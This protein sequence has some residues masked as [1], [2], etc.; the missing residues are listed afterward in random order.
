MKPRKPPKKVLQ[1]E[2]MPRESL[3][4]PRSWSGPQDRLA[5]MP[6]GKYKGYYLKDV[7]T[8]YLK[9][10]VLN[11][12]D[13]GMAQWLADELQRRPEFRSELG[14]KRSTAEC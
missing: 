9:W 13:Q 12:Q 3:F 11:Y 2:E 8:D 6:W 4:P 1:I 14:L 7:P 10:C 5:K